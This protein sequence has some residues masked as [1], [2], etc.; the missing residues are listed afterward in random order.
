MKE[1]PSGAPRCFSCGDDTSDWDYI[2]YSPQ[3]VCGAPACHREMRDANRAI[4]EDAQLRAADD[5][6]ERYR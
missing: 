5:N 3:W 6:Y 1:R 4:D 2:G